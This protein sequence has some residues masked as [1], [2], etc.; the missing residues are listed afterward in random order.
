MLD[1]AS[2]PGTIQI[3]PDGSGVVVADYRC[4]PASTSASIEAVSSTGSRQRGLNR[5][6]LG[7]LQGFLNPPGQELVVSSGKEEIVRTRCL[8]HGIRQVVADASGQL[9]KLIRDLR[10]GVT[11][12]YGTDRTVKV[13]Q[14]DFRRSENSI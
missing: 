2:E 10:C 7:N 12:E 6:H 14:D 5:R 1:H 8:R 13:E 9:A 3:T 4:G 11:V